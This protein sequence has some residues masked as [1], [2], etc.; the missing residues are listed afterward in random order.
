MI[1]TN[2]NALHKIANRQISEMKAK[3][4]DVFYGKN[5][6]LNMNNTVDF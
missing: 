3:I 4:N 2:L 1:A 5:Y 6:M